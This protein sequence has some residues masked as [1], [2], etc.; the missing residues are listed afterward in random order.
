MYRKVKYQNTS[1]EINESVEG[2][3]LETQV[4]RALTNGEGIDATA[5]IIYTERR[6]GVQPEYNPRA[7]KWEIAVDAMN[8]IDADNKTKRKDNIAKL[9]PEKDGNNGDSAG[10]SK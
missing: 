3:T 2:E 8:K 9:Y 10:D 7:D 1:I 5:N 4:H 6:D